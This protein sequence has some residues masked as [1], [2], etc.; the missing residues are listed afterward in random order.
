M[1]HLS[2]AR[3]QGRSPESIARWR[4]SF[5]A[6]ATG[7]AKQK[8]IHR[9][10]EGGFKPI[11]G[12]ICS[13]GADPLEGEEGIGREV[14]AFRLH[15]WQVT[16][17]MYEE[18]DPQHRFH[19]WAGKHPLAKKRKQGEDRCPVVNVTWYDAWCFAA[20]CGRLLPTELEWEHAC[21]AGSTT[22]R[23][24]GNE[25]ADLAKYAW[26]FRNSNDS[27]H[28]VGELAANGNGLFDMHGNVWEWCEDHLEPGATARV[29]RGWSW[30]DHGRNC[31][32]A[33]RYWKEPDYRSL[34]VGFR[35]AAVPDVGA[36][37]GEGERA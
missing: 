6:L 32:S 4:S 9:E 13:Y 22:R 18:F 20:W 25:E 28:P 37:P 36:K 29:L 26:Y 10:I 35:L 5:E 16:N 11:P 34:H 2:F 3:M 12:G 24:F 21:R 27:T 23:C 15:Q 1:I 31:R 8:R 14:S 30:Y 19:R 7:T 33:F 17:E